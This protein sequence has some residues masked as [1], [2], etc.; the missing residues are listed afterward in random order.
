MAY[1]IGVHRDR[2]KQMDKHFDSKTAQARWNQEWERSSVFRPS[3]DADRE[4]FTII[5]PPPNVTGVLHVGHVLGDAVQDHLIRWN[6]MRGYDTL[7]LPGSDHAGIA[8]QKV[9]E[10]ALLAKGKKRADMTR[11][12]FLDYAWA[13]KDEKHGVIVDQL[14][15]LGCAMDWSR[16]A[17]TLDEPRSRA[18][19]EVFVRLHEKGLIYQGDYI[20]N[21]CP[22][23]QTAISDEEVEYKEKDSHLWWIKYQ[24]EDGGHLV[25]ATTRPETMLGDTGVAVSPDD[26]EKVEMVGK[27]ATLPI[28]GRRLPIVSDSIVDKE[29]GSGFVKVTPAHDPNDFEIAGRHQ[30]P[31]VVVIDR[32]GRMTAEAGKQ[33]EGLDRFDCRKKVIA[34]LEEDGYL[35]KTEPYRHSVGHHDRCG[36]VIEPL[37]SREWFVKMQPLAKPA[38]E[39]VERG[40]VT[41]YPDRWRNVYMSWMTNIRDWCISRQLWWGHRIPVWYC[42]DGHT[43]VSRT[44]P[45]ACETCGSADIRQDEN[46]LD[47]W[48]SSW[49]WT[50]SPMGWP[51]DTSDLKRFHPTQVLVTGYEIIFFWV[52][53]MIMAAL[54]FVDE[55][56]FS[57][58]FL[59]GIVRDEKGRKMSKSLG[60]S[61]D[62]LDIIAKYG[63]DAFRFTLSML[64]PPGKDV[65]FHED[66]VEMGRNFVNKI[67]QA[68]RMV[69]SAVE[70]NDDL[71]LFQE[72]GNG[73]PPGAFEQAWRG[74]HRSRLAFE[75]ELQWEDRWIVSA[76][77]RCASETNTSFETWRLNEGTARIY[78]FFWHEFCDWYLELAKIRL[79]GDGDKRTVLAVLLYVLGESVKLIHP[80]MPYVS[81]ELW[82][83]LPMTQ[84]LLMENRYPAQRDDLRDERAD[85]QMEVFQS[86]VTAV[87]NIR[88]TYR[89]DPGARIAARVKTPD[90]DSGI[91]SETVEGIRQLAKIDELQ[92]GPDVA[93]ERG[94]AAT[95]IGRFEV[96]VPLAGVVDLEAEAR[97]LEGEKSKIEIELARVDGKL[98][99]E[100]FVNRA[101][102][103]VVNKEREK[104]ERLESERDKLVESIAIIKTD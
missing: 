26:E 88:A 34:Q 39:V 20:V 3:G 29:F 52:A 70:S 1:S 9:V 87:R 89:V 91:V 41:F 102:P 19:R 38:I 13:W 23:C 65:L 36:T 17:F 27:T 97:R 44:D 79:Y 49:L 7:W 63:T 33:F 50:F 40:E 81:E 94:S 35:I 24:I 76:L 59:T 56:P 37:L 8:T 62:P 45:T 71:V 100:K 58:V 47:T 93:K 22:S 43:T 74:A 55:I 77:G 6:R 92:L 95:P 28:V 90:G 14:R 96:V 30:L 53:R 69:M 31:P 78:D 103:D 15:N 85:E 75:P 10:D 86:I 82:D 2:K 48:F 83:I 25:V 66:K 61:P 46:V 73:A 32:S 5:L 104:K 99:N 12:Q 18:V 84:G 21:W 42:Q 64:S 57:H 16:E 68:S 101:N 60:N 54:E 80:L 11:E 4:P 72:S 98:G 67:W 51:D